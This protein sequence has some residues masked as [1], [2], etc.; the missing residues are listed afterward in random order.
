[1]MWLLLFPL[2]SKECSVLSKR[3]FLL[4][5]LSCGLVSAWWASFRRVDRMVS[6]LLFLVNST[7]G[8]LGAVVNLATLSITVVRD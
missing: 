3:S 2:V 6:W 4:S 5:G 7:S 8:V 1:M